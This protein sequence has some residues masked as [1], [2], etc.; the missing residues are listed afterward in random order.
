MRNQKMNKN[1]LNNL[2]FYIAEKKR[3]IEELNNLKCNI[4]DGYSSIDFTYTGGGKVSD[5]GIL[6]I[7]LHNIKYEKLINKRIN[8]LNK[9][10]LKMY[11]IIDKIDDPKVKSIVELRAIQGKKWEEIGDIVGY[12]LSSC[13]KIYNKFIEN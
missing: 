11:A 4:K 3:L 9:I 7:V 10:I 1:E 5:D 13:V 8:K 2:R 6:N 12:E